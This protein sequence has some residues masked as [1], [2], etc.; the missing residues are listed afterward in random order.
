VTKLADDLEAAGAPDSIRIWCMME[1]PK[2]ILNSAMIAASHERLECLVLGT[3]DL[4]QDLHALHTALRLPMLTS[5]GLCLLA[6]RANGLAIL[7]GVA[8]DLSDE[9]AFR[10]A[11]LQGRE[12]GFDGK[13]LVHPKQIVDCNE[14]FSPSAIDVTQAQNVVDAFS[15]ARAAGQGVATLN[16]RLIEGLHVREAERVLALHKAISARI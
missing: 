5:L 15:V 1:T 6:A 13:T 7:D 14:A 16:G 10:A 12:M 4:T 8:L 11:C 3:S 2:A 9:A